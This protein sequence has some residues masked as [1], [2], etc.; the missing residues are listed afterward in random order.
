VKLALV[1]VVLAGCA[2]QSQQWTYDRPQAWR[3]QCASGRHQSPVE[4]R[5]ASHVTRPPLEI[6]WQPSSLVGKHNGHTVQFEVGPGSHLG[7]LTLKQFHYHVPSE[8]TLD[9]KHTALEL[10]FVH[11]DAAGRPA[12]VIAVL[13]GA[14]KPDPANA[15]GYGRLASGLPQHEG[16]EREYQN[17]DLRQLLPAKRGRYEYDGSLTTPPCSEGVRWIV[18]AESVALEPAQI[19]AFSSVP[20]LK[21]TARPTQ[22]LHDRRLTISR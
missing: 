8:H 21:G 1:A 10:H 9:G 14:G 11:V 19:E 13:V 22:P 17:V 15:S 3:D 7:E 12:L 6:E 4:L 2:N 5:G 16:D 18:M 20:H